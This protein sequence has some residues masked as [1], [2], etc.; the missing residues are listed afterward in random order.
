MRS[1]LLLRVSLYA[2]VILGVVLFANPGLRPAL[3]DLHMGVG[4][5]A[6]VLALVALRPLPAV[7]ASTVRLVARFLPLLPLVIGL[8]IR[9]ALWGGPA[10]FVVHALLGFA[11]VAVVEMAA[12]QQRR[13]QAGV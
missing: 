10:I 9:F 3:R 12:G 11:T 5:L 8:G 6:A 1:L 13:A 7:P 4:L 2:Q